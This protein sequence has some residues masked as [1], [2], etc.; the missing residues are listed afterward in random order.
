M[1]HQDWNTLYVKLKDKSKATNVENKTNQ[2]KV[3]KDNNFVLQKD[4]KLEKRIDE[5]DMKHQKISKELS[6]QIQQGR[7]SKGLTQ[8]QLANQ[9]S[10]PINEINQMESGQYLN[11]RQKISK[12]KRFLSIK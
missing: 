11:N 9:L 7:L 10:I 8:K 5:G 6:K 1:E 3:K 4:S 2:S 12:V